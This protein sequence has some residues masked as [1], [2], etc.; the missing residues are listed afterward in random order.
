MIR[1][2]L[3]FLIPV[4]LI[5]P[6]VVEGQV[7]AGFTADDTAG[8][9]PMVVH[10][11]NTSTGATSYSWNLGNGTLSSL[12]DVS[13]AY[14][15]AGTY[16]I[17][18]V[19]SN[20]TTSSTRTMTIR[21]YGLPTVNFTASDTNICPGSSVTF[22]STSVPNAWGGLTYNW[23]FGD[24]LTSSA[25]SPT[26][27]YPLS[28]DYNVTLFA[29]N[30][31]GCINSRSRIPYIHVYTRPSVGFT[32]ASTFFCHAPGMEAFTN[33]TIGTGPF[34][35]LWRFGD[36]GT[37]TLANPPHNYIAPGNYDITLR[38]TDGHGCTDSV[39]FPTFISVANVHAAFT[40]VAAACVNFPV[41]FTNTSTTHISSQWDFGDGFTS[42]SESPDHVYSV[43]G[44][45]NVKLI[46]FDGICY[47]TV[48]HS[49]DIQHPT[50]SFT[51]S[52]L[53][54]CSPPQTLTFSASVPPGST[55][56][57]SSLLFGSLGSGTTISHLFPA[58]YDVGVPIGFI[59]SVTMILTNS[60]GCKDTVGRRDTVNYLKLSI[61]GGPFE[62]CAP[63]VGHFTVEATSTVHDVFSGYPW[64]AHGYPPPFSTGY[65]YPYPI[66]SYSWNLGDG[67]L[68]T[69]PAPTH[70]YTVVG[71]RYRIAAT[72]VTANGCSFSDFVP[73]S[74]KVG[75]MPPTPTASRHPS[76]VCAG[77]PVY[78]SASGTGTFDRFNWDFGDGHS[79]SLANPTHVYT[80]PGIFQADVV[81]SYNGCPSIHAILKDTVDSPNAYISY[82]FDC[83]PRTEISFVDSS[84][85]DD[86]HLWQFG[87]GFTSTARN[88]V[89]NYPAI[90]IYNV[91]LTTF[92]IASGC[93]DTST[94]SL[95]LNK[96]PTTL[97]P[98][99][100]SI[101]RD[102]LDTITA[103]A[104]GVAGTDET[105]VE[106]YKWYYDGSPGDSFITIYP[107]D[108]V[109]HAF[110]STGSH[111]VL[112]QFTDNHGCKDT[113]IKNILVAKP[114]DSFVVTPPAGCAPLPVTFTD[115]TTDVT[116]IPVTSYYWR[117]GDGSSL[118]TTTPVVSHTYTANGTYY[119]KEVV[120]DSLGCMDSLISATHPVVSKPTAAFSG[121]VTSVCA[122]SNVH[123]TNGTTGTFT[124][125]WLFGDGDT[126]VVTSPNHAYAS[127]GTYT[128][129]LIVTNSSGCKDTLTRTNYIVVK[130]LPVPSFYMDDSF[131]VCSPLNVNFHNTS[132]GAT[133]YFWTF[134]DGT[135]S[136]SP[137]PSDVYITPGY[138]RVK[139][140]ALNAY[141]CTDTAIG[142]V[143]LF[144]Y[145]GAFSYTPH[146]GCNPLSVH[147]TASVPPV[148]SLVWD[149]SDGVTSTPSL[150]DTI[151]H[152]YS[153]TGTFIP[154]LIL[155]DS[156]GCV[157]FSVGTDTIKIDNI[158]AGYTITP[159]PVCPYNVITFHDT[160]SSYFSPV[161]SWLWTFAPGYSSTL[162]TPTFSYSVSGTHPVT[163]AVTDAWGCTSL[164]TKNVIV[165][166]VPSPI[167]GPSAICIGTVI[168]L[169]D[170]ATGGVWSST[171]TA[172]ATIGSSSGILTGMGIGVTTISYVLGSGCVATKTI[173]VNPALTSISGTATV[174]VASITT[175]SNATA[176]GT[177]SSGA[178]TIATVGSSTGIVTGVAAGTATI[179]YTVGGC[180]STKVVTVYA[181]PGSITGNTHV[182]VGSVTTLAS[183][184]SGGVWSSGGPAVAGIGSSSGLVTGVSAGTTTITYTIP[185]GCRVTAPFTVNAYPA[186]VAGGSFIC[187]GG[188]AAYTDATSGGLWA[189]SNTAIATVG[190]VSGIVNGIAVGFATISYSV[191]GCAVTKPVTVNTLPPAIYG[192][193]EVCTGSTITL[194]DSTLGGVWSSGS[195]ANAT[196]GSSSGIVT[197]VFLGTATI[198]YSLGA[199]CVVTKVVSVDP[200]PSTIS[201]STNLCVGTTTTYSDITVG[202]TWSCGTPSL[203]IIGSS[204]GVAT[205]VATGPAVITYT[206]PTGCRSTLAISVNSAPPIT[207]LTNLCAYG[208]TLTIHDIDPA[209]S[210]SSTLV[211]ILNL[212]G[213][214]GKISTHAPGT[215][216]IVYSLFLGCSYTATITI[217]PLPSSIV[218][219][220]HLCVG[221][222]AGF[223]DT[224]SSGGVWTST[225]AVVGSIDS[226]SGMATALAGGLTRIR[227]TLA[228]GCKVDTPLT[229]IPIP[230]PG[231]ITGPGQVCIG[232]AITLAD[233]IPGGVWSSTNGSAA[234]TGGTVTGVIAGVDTISY[235]VSNI[236]GSAASTHV[237][238]VNPLPDAGTIN[239]PSVVCVG[240]TIQLTDAVS[241]GIWSSWNSNATVVSGR[242]IGIT[243]GIDTI[244]Y[245]YTNMCGTA[246]VKFGIQ[247]DPLP[248]A[249]S[250]SG[251]SRVCVGDTIVLSGTVS[252]GTL[253]LSNTNATLGAWVVTGVIAGQDTVIYTVSNSCGSAVVIKPITIDPLPYAGTIYGDSKLCVGDSI[254]LTDSLSGGTWTA[255]NNAVMLTGSVT[256]IGLTAGTDTIRYSVTN[257]C[258]TD[259]ASATVT[260]NPLPDGLVI[261]RNDFVLSVASG[262]AAY[263]WILDG[264]PIPGATNNTYNFKDTG[265]YSVMVTNEFGC[266]YTYAPF[267]ITDCSVSDI[268]VYPNPTDGVVYIQWCRQLNARVS[269]MDGKIVKEVDNVSQITIG[270]LPNGI[271]T[272]TLYDVGNNKILTKRITKLTR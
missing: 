226:F 158:T 227:F 21:V 231:T 94:Y 201:G 72:I 136:S 203:V 208:D 195:V 160:S 80:A 166:S 268:Q 163:L 115:V 235:V 19:A 55:V 162:S 161:T 121:S 137:N 266:S 130:P 58:L 70:T 244:I 191:A 213:G 48:I 148:A 56:T 247:V 246:T 30:V 271:Y 113:L 43:P 49:V 143:N 267:I 167:I 99:K 2:I 110:S 81:T 151:T 114:L 17:T 44:T 98:Y 45:Y 116:G 156:F 153:T 33:T 92:N 65:T 7:V 146:S 85:G 171:N 128:V 221:T 131:A 228:T 197:G 42:V 16:T 205:G 69:A 217:N 107:F 139:L 111:Q 109:Y 159:N 127:A 250:L 196:V 38:V 249:G 251:S 10:F 32:V 29:T 186:P 18:L 170:T 272:L 144:G 256:V 13:G 152:V 233:T 3:K 73:D 52:P 252:G 198:S 261:T 25:S 175:L 12:T 86:T 119:I 172:V 71:G 185:T 120:T 216:T 123:F 1:S 211:T 22:T 36:G 122:H 41:T 257:T 157:N 184:P 215:A 31:K 154:K 138:Y 212:G 77:Q 141:S 241:G 89:H 8:C 269:C 149:F 199:G 88:P 164:V 259:V 59:D 63:L 255:S 9:A 174:C 95:K 53:K 183:T 97:T 125:L 168:A 263:Q 112:L 147:F 210:Y 242:V 4:F 15:T 176:G 68:S 24:G 200:L 206:L 182:C 260:V 54:P 5:I 270:E 262:Y 193:D 47:D 103:T 248:D 6:I 74:L 207:G 192:P 177:W 61:G 126:S 179:S 11:T 26:H 264:T 219:A 180:I 202:G 224:P 169:T 57:W 34:S 64:Y 66:T 82:R 135:S 129:K 76:H 165:N 118:L 67:T 243:A 155:T 102:V 190:S 37:S 189:S 104:P 87:D 222:T 134:G 236:C 79:D 106:K 40:S 265:A 133:S 35:S 225:N 93:R 39:F 181:L 14:L 124:S 218:G 142:H 238:T 78:F 46:I 117:F 84:L 194:A 101:C 20:G 150:I 62:G 239:G 105:W 223:I 83:S 91:T 204:T 132:T 232:Q 28:G 254:M 60:I 187:I 230:A 23:N 214:Y 100:Y 140:L 188:L 245:T 50:G 220:S 209:G 178:T 145:S 27:T 173:T 96:L 229:V 108:T 253:T 237:V 258:G 90:G 51:I 240:D 75:A 234:V